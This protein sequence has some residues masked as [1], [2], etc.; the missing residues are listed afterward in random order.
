ML[1]SNRPP[2]NLSPLVIKS[3][4][5]YDPIVRVKSI[6]FLGV[7]FDDNMSFK[8][9]I[10][11]LSQRLARVASL[12]YRVSQFMPPFVLT[13][14]YHAHVSSILNYCN[15][16]WSNTYP[17]HLQPI[18]KIQKRIIRITTNSEFL[19]HTAPLF[20]QTNILNIE[21]LRKFTLAIHFFKNRNEIL[22]PLQA[23]HQYPTR[24]RDRPRPIRH[25]RT[26]FERSFVHQ[27]PLIW[28]ELLDICPNILNHN[29]SLATFKKHLKKFLTSRS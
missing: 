20:S 2:V 5:N 17:T 19:A 1:F 24:A 22:P 10:T 28:N 4:F 6:K 18:I 13:T 11:Y 7:H 23:Q 3:N 21:N 14:M 26:V 27:L 29:Q 9:H 15:I 8:T 25:Q 12:M 16:I